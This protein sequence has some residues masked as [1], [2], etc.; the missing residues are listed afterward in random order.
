MYAPFSSSKTVSA[1]SVNGSHASR[2][3]FRKLIRS[4][5]AVI[6]VGA[7]IG[8][9]TI[10][11]S[12]L[13]GGEGRVFA[14][15]PS[16]ETRK[17]LQRNLE[18]NN[19]QNVSVVPSAAWNE[20]GTSKFN[21]HPT[22]RGGSSLREIEGSLETEDVELIPVD[23]AINEE[24]WSRVRLVKIDIEGA[25]C[26]AV[27]GMG[28]LLDSNH[29]IAVITEMEDP[30]LRGFGRSASELLSLFEKKGFFA[31]RIPNSYDVTEYIR[32]HRKLNVSRMS[33]APGESSYVVFSRD[34]SL[35]NY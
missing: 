30:K 24:E 6:D 28:R 33:C 5:D 31:Y 1:F 29:D 26:H 9:F 2:A 21:K 10:L 25:E 13:V 18:L 35:R 32:P 19:I 27:E 14:F 23:S 16:L 3:V 8:Y 34:P 7:N 4:G 17:R 11:S 20:N 15:E 22:D 12:M